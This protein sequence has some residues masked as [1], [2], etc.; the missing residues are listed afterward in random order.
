LLK[1]SLRGV[2]GLDF[3]STEEGIAET[4]E[5]LKEQEIREK[6]NGIETDGTCL[7]T[8]KEKLKKAKDRKKKMTEHKER[9]DRLKRTNMM[10]DSLKYNLGGF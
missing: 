3:T 7:P 8:D 2:E 4:K 10:L 6:L 9:M 1:G 5:W